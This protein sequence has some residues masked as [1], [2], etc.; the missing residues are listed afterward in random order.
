MSNIEFDVHMAQMQGT[1][2][3]ELRQKLSG[4]ISGKYENVMQEI[5]NGWKGENSQLFL[6]KAKILQEQMEHTVSTIEKAQEALKDAVLKA[7][8]TEE[9]VKEIGETRRYK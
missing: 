5:C 2:I 4:A 1:H 9:K 7:E 3:E 6:N 8:T